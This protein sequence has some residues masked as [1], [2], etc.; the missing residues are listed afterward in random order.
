MCMEQCGEIWLYQLFAAYAGRNML[1][2]PPSCEECNMF[3]PISE[4]E[5]KD[6]KTSISNVSRRNC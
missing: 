1:A 5:L 4:E 6:E 2:W 3:A